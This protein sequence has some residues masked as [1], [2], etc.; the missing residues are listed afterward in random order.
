MTSGSGGAGNKTGMPFIPQYYNNFNFYMLDYNSAFAPRAAYSGG[1]ATI[2]QGVNIFDGTIYS[3][4][5]VTLGS[6]LVKSSSIRNTMNY[7]GGGGGGGYD[8]GGTANGNYWCYT[9]RW[10]QVI[11]NTDIVLLRH[12]ANTEYVYSYIRTPDSS[13]DATSTVDNMT[14]NFHPTEKIIGGTIYVGAGQ[15]LTIE[16]GVTVRPKKVIVDGGTLIIRGSYSTDTYNLEA[17]VYVKGDTGEVVLEANT[18]IKADIYVYGG[19]TLQIASNVT[20]VNNYVPGPASF[21]SSN[22]TKNISVTPFTADG[23]IFIFGPNSKDASG[24]LVGAGHL[25]NI[26]STSG[27]LNSIYMT[28]GKIHMLGGAFMNDINTR[29]KPIDEDYKTELTDATMNNIFCSNR[30]LAPGA[31]TPA[32]KFD[33]PAYNN[34]LD[35]GATIGGGGWTKGEYSDE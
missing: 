23:G 7:N 13:A 33:D 19:A 9:L 24:T 11:R 35:F 20:W 26:K 34:C 32:A 4:R 1:N 16:R 15:T 27:H 6:G 29:W 5:G 25:W 18:K 31:A 3:Y 22:A 30:Y 17:P 12:P 8:F 2:L 28:A 14:Q 10:D 21:I